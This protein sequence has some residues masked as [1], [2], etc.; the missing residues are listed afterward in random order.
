MS[1]IDDQI[2]ALRILPAARNLAYVSPKFIQLYYFPMIFKRKV[3][4]SWIMRRFG[5]DLMNFVSPS[6][7]PRDWLGNNIKCPPLSVCLPA[8][9]S[10]YLSSYLS[11]YLFVCTCIHPSSHPSTHPAIYPFIHP[12]IRSLL[13]WLALQKSYCSRKREKP[14]LMTNHDL[15][16][17][18]ATLLFLRVSNMMLSAWGLWPD[19]VWAYVS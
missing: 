9:L 15:F 2:I 1:V 6:Y 12:S 11:V 14:F 3:R 8:C 19:C 18:I 7:D 4:L 17:D 16:Q 10:S 13:S 5:C